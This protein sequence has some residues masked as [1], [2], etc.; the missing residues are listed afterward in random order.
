MK[1]PWSRQRREKFNRTIAARRDNA[2]HA[3]ESPPANPEPEIL[4]AENDTT[5]IFI[6]GD[7]LRRLRLRNCRAWFAEDMPEGHK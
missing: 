7:K 2:N 1:K 4:G 5:L 3:P 6:D